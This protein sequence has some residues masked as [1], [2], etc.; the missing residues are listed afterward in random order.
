M[1]LTLKSMVLSWKKCLLVYFLHNKHE[2]GIASLF[3]EHISSRYN[4]VTYVIF[5]KFE[6]RLDDCCFWTLKRMFY[7]MIFCGRDK[8]YKILSSLNS[9]I[10]NGL[11]K[12][13]IFFHQAEMVFVIV[14][15]LNHFALEYVSSMNSI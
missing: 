2:W 3:H 6:A 15:F 9:N 8:D 14:W 12:F 10:K 5:I 1:R 7:I 4:F 11:K 13:S